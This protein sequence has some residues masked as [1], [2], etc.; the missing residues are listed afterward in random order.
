[1]ILFHV[2]CT[3]YAQGGEK[4]NENKELYIFHVMSTRHYSKTS[5]LG[6][7]ECVFVLVYSISWLR[8][9]TETLQKFKRGREAEGNAGSVSLSVQGRFL[10]RG[11][12]GVQTDRW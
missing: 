1:M 5:R 4:G 3:W 8:A 12:A 9:F 10:D 7:C 11:A 6:V 2:L